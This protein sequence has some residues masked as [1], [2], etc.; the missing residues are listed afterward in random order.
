MAVKR[1]QSAGRVLAV[2]EEVSRSQ[3]IGVS[4]LA[5]LL[6]A[7]KSA[8]QR[9]LMTLA[10]AGW[11]QPAANEARAWE[12]SPL[13]LTLARPPRSNE[14]LREQVRPALERLRDLTGETVYLTVPHKGRFV[15]IEAVESA[16]LLRVVQR[17]GITVEIAGSATARAWLACLSPEEREAF[18][19]HAPDP[20]LAAEIETARDLG[21]A[22]NDGR[23]VPG[24]VTFA[25][26][27][28]DFRARP[29][30]T[31]VVTGPA[32]RLGRERWADIT[33]HLRETAQQAARTLAS[34]P[35]PV[36]NA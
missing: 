7:D 32:E 6:G 3:P 27:L 28:L 31:I 18:L 30:G 17:V 16:N 2:F 34:E 12:L 11:I 36:V 26:A 29:V 21:Y 8:I 25:A 1:S 23:I 24:T 4:A 35:A 33:R 22:V 13:I 19:G 10:D 9:D 14:A 15:V 20:A 5:R